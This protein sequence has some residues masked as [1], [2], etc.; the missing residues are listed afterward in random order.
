MMALPKVTEDHRQVRELTL[1][2]GRALVDRLARRHLGISGEAF[3]R[4]W[5]AG[6]LDAQAERPEIVHLAMLLPLAR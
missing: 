6:E 1:E 2:E 3:M 4:A 5:E